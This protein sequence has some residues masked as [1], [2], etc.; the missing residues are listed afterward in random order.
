MNH[1][2]FLSHQQTA[3]LI[4]NVGPKRTVLVLGENGIGKTSLYHTL[5]QDSDFD[6]H[7]KVDPIDCTQLSDGSLFMPDLDRER[8]VSTELPNERLGVG[9]HN[10]KG[11]DGARP[12]LGMFDEIAKVPQ[13]VKNMIAPMIYEKRVGK[14]KWP[15]RSVWFAGSNLGVEGLGDLIQAH[16]RSR[17]IV[18]YMR[19]PDASEWLNNFAVPRGLNPILLA[20]VEENPAVLDSFID[21]LPGGKH[22]G[23]DMEKDNPMPFNPKITQDA[24]ASPRTLHAASDVLDIMDKIDGQTL[25]AALEGTVGKPFASVLDSFI[26]FGQQLPPIN[27]IKANPDTAPIPSNKIAQQVQVFQFITRTQDRDDA[28]AF[29]KYMLRLQPEMQSLFC[30]RVADSERFV[31]YTSVVEFGTMLTN[32][33]IYYKV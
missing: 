11:I 5:A 33:K 9:K 19:K 28:Q 29:S 20:C 1:N 22:A 16:L 3:D 21:Y 14:Y 7:I 8:G 17:Q 10:H 31:M 26:R 24:Y 23:R 15:E 27:Q 12:V 30:R 2:L 18:V 25:R 4:K 32:N 13:F 6:D